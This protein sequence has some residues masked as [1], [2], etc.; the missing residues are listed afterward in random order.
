M[1]NDDLLHKN[2]VDLI[3]QSKVRTYVMSIKDNRPANQEEIDH[4]VTSGR[5]EIGYF[6]DNSDTGEIWFSL[7]GNDKFKIK[8]I[9]DRGDDK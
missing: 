9:L 3:K 2:I 8:N 1:K 4:L 6:W 7:D 5:L